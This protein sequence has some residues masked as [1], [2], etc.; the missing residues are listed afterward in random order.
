MKNI[1]IALP[2]LFLMACSSSSTLPVKDSDTSDKI[3]YRTQGYYN[4]SVALETAYDKLPACP[5]AKPI[6]ADSSI[7]KKIR[8]IDDAA[9]TAIKEA[10]VAVR[11]PGFSGDKMTTFITAATALTKAFTDITATLPQKE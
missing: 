7:K 10:Q 5:I 8:K 3:V 9:H 6:C 11:T 4:A 2:L 1:L